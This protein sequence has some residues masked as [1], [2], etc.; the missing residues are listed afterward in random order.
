MKKLVFNLK[1]NFNQEEMIAYEDYFAQIV[2]IDADVT[3][4][5]S[6][7]FLYLFNESNYILGAQ[8]VSRYTGGAYTGE[9]SAVQLKSLG[10]KNVIVGHSERMLVENESVEVLT[11]KIMNCLDNNL[12]VIL[13]I[14]ETKEERKEGK[15]EYLIKEKLSKILSK[16]NPSLISSISIA[17]EPIWAIGTGDVVSNEELEKIM[18]L[19][20][21]YVSTNFRVIPT[22]LYGGSV[23]V[24][25]LQELAK[26]QNC[27]GY[28]IGS[29]SK[30][31]K[32]VEDI[33]NFCK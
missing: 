21:N 3:I 17:Y 15:T 6:T 14:G 5:P 9:T 7:P 20:K 1:C 31:L 33:I 2:P 30:S 22:T 18:T 28:L 11:N 29:A 24:Q 32:D 26:V 27:D 8:D 23:S 10:V 19:I 25:H 12:S 16:I 13:C 4:C